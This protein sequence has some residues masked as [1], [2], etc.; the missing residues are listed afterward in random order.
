MC[1]L[2]IRKPPAWIVKRKYNCQP[3]YIHPTYAKPKAGRGKQ[4]WIIWRYY[5]RCFKTLQKEHYHG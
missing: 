4:E 1:F 2:V 5:L 3:D